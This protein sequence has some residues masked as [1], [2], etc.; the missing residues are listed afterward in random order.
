MSVD[1]LPVQVAEPAVHAELTVEAVQPEL[2]LHP[3]VVVW[4]VALVQVVVVPGLQPIAV[5][6]QAPLR[7]LSVT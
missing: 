5:G 7:Q 6:V 1:P 4:R 2:S 3:R